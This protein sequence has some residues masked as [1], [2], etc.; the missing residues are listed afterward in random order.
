MRGLDVHRGSGESGLEGGRNVQE[1]DG[2]GERRE[3][4]K[5]R[6]DLQAG[7]EIFGSQAAEDVD[8]DDV[9]ELHVFEEDAD[10]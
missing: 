2:G 8:A 4:G 10:A 7:L 6:H 3:I 9:A 5:L 1:L